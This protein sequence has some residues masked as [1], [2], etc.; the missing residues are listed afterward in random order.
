MRYRRFQ[1]NRSTISSVTYCKNA[2]C[3]TKF[4][5]LFT[6]GCLSI[7]YTFVRPCSQITGSGRG[8]G[9]E[10]A[11]R[12]ANL[13]AKVACVDVDNTS[14]EET[15]KLIESNVKGAKAKAYT[16]NVAIVSET[17][18]LVK[19]VEHELGSVEILINNAAVIVGHTFVGGED[20]TISAIININLLGNFWVSRCKPIIGTICKL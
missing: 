10:L 5:D 18:A 12:F 20:H 19:K 13:G 17:T 16:V 2:T 15:V 6:L 1:A 14:N 4:F 7:S 3:S 11:L 8:L 9:R